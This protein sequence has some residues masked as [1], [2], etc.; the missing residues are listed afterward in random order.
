[1]SRH[2][3]K[4]SRVRWVPPPWW[5]HL[6]FI[7]FSSGPL[8][9]IFWPILNLPINLILDLH[10]IK[11]VYADVR[12]CLYQAISPLDNAINQFSQTKH[13]RDKC[14]I[15]TNHDTRKNNSFTIPCTN[16]WNKKPEKLCQSLSN[17]TFNLTCTASILDWY[18]GP[19]VIHKGRFTLGE[20]TF[21]WHLHSLG[22]R[23]AEHAASVL[24]LQNG[25]REE[26]CALCDGTTQF[27]IR[28][29]FLKIQ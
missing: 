26:R 3:R 9:G 27:S 18:K 20:M 10:T 8:N 29:D 7:K 25:G 6:L 15:V 4:I 12:I 23:S 1:M 19:W 14:L 11:T 28:K 5:E 13:R 21:S 2:D 22:R 16:Y 24:S 17:P